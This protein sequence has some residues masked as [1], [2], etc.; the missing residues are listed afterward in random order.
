MGHRSRVEPALELLGSKFYPA[1]P[2]MSGKPT[3]LP[4]TQL[5]IVGQ[6]QRPTQGVPNAGQA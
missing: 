6:D 2:I 4:S 3:N 1:Q 5:P